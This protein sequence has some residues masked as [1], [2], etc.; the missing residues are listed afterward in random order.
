M[1]K[2]IARWI[3][4]WEMKLFPV[5]MDKMYVDQS[6]KNSQYGDRNLFSAYTPYGI[7]QIDSE[8]AK[9]IMEGDEPKELREDIKENPH[10]HRRIKRNLIFNLNQ[11]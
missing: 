4:K 8:F 9:R 3:Y 6:M 5:N 1:K 2:G 10:L 7:K 11:R